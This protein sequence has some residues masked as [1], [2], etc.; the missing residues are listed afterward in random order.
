M[1]KIMKKIVKRLQ[2]SALC[3]ATES[4][5][6]VLTAILNIAPPILRNKLK[7]KI[8]KNFLYGYHGNPIVYYQLDIDEREG[9]Q[10]VSRHILSSLDEF[11]SDQI[12]KTLDL[13][14]NK[15]KLHL[16]LDKQDAYLNKLRISEGDD[17]IRITISFYPHI[18]KK[19]A[20]ISAL[21]L[22]GLKDA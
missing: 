4:E 17:V 20:L 1:R 19:E 8:A 6:K 12:K 9:A 2:V 22:M 7:N 14:F 5:E 10:E 16:R 13:R 18:R 11:D 15:G 21:T 3:H